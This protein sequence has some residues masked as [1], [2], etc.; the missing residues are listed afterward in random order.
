[1]WLKVIRQTMSLKGIIYPFSDAVRSATG[2]GT[3]K[4]YK[5]ALADY[6]ESWSTAL[7]LARSSEHEPLTDRTG[8]VTDYRFPVFLQN[9]DLL[10]YRQ[11]Y[12]EIGGIY[13][14]EPDGFEE[15]IVTTGISIDNHFSASGNLLAWT[16]V[17]RDPRYASKNFS[18]VVI[19]NTETGKKTRLTSRKRYFSPSISPDG[20]R[21]QWWKS[22]PWVKAG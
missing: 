8:T 19:W 2:M 21:S 4:F 15:R 18:N 16:E 7:R 12:N 11:S 10:A 5:K 3:R 13:R 6:K 1:M 9:G 14:I 22:I 17:S 20:T